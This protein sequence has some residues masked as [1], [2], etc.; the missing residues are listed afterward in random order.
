MSARQRTA[1]VCCILSSEVRCKPR[2]VHALL[3]IL[4]AMQALC[5]ASVLCM[6]CAHR[7]IQG[8]ICGASCTPRAYDPHPIPFPAPPSPAHTC[9][10][11][12]QRPPDNARRLP[13]AV[14]AQSCHHTRKAVACAATD[15]CCAH[16]SASVSLSLQGKRRGHS[17]SA[18][19]TP[20]SV[21]ETDACLAT[22]T[23]NGRSWTQAETSLLTA[24]D[25]TS[26][27]LMVVTGDAR[28]Q[29]LVRRTAG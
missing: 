10:E 27:G 24:I 1:T 26:D 6:L 22:C 5:C 4:C 15:R 16:P 21:R 9:T 18:G 25:I 28:G 3:W 2:P 12:M 7:K 8:T 20:P 11:H 13:L 17:I 29:V 19:F 14:H 23:I